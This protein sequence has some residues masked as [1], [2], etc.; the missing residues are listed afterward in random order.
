[1]HRSGI[2]LAVGLALAGCAALQP[3]RDA[4]PP[5]AA[6]EPVAA[7]A[8]VDDAADETVAAPPPQRPQPGAGAL[9]RTVASLGNPAEGGLWLVT[10]LVTQPGQGR[11]R[12]VQSGTTVVLEL[13]PSG[14]ARDGGSRLSLEGYRALG[15]SPVALPVLDVFRP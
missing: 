11:V 4:P 5:E 12:D 13:R 7:D 2:I 15:L 14:G 3:D 10:G 8:V 9:G 6:P 1:M